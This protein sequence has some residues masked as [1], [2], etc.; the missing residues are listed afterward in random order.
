MMIIFYEYQSVIKGYN[1]FYDDG[2]RD[3]DVLNAVIVTK[4]GRTI[5]HICPFLYANAF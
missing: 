3:G 5:P 4:V 1:D 2:D